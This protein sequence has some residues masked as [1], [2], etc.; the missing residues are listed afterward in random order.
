MKKFKADEYIYCQG[1]NGNEMYIILSGKVDIY[2][3]DMDGLSVKLS[4]MGPGELVGELSLIDNQP[5][6]ASA[7]AVT[8]TLVISINRSKFEPFIVSQPEMAYKIMKGLSARIR[9]LSDELVKLK[10]GEVN[11]KHAIEDAMDP[12][13]D[14]QAAVNQPEALN[15]K[16]QEE[17]EFD[18]ILFPQGHKSYTLCKTVDS[19]PYLID[20]KGKC[21]V[22][23]AEFSMPVPRVTRLKLNRVEPDTR[24]VYIDFDP[25]WYSIWIC[26]KCCYSSYY[27]DYDQVPDRMLKSLKEKLHL[28]AG[29]VDITYTK[30]RKLDQ[31]FNAFYLALYTAKSCKAAPLKIARLWLQLSWLYKDAGDEEM[32]KVA[33]DMSLNLYYD[34]LYRHNLNLPAEQEQQCFIILA[35]LY[36]VKGDTK[37]AIR[38][39]HTALK[40]ETGNKQL[41][42]QARDRIQDIRDM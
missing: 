39:Y 34:S 14:S 26:P 22:C 25:L 23:G 16:T 32:H 9:F 40:M 31:V 21:P 28:I 19:T 36:L 7:I 35:E 1:D 29:K 30:P 33:A 15:P 17:G 4:E 2:I 3:N 27:F 12:D 24:K 5:R 38:H 10:E 6:S 11:G 37:E 20:K 41:I 8:D 42:N 13:N 18:A